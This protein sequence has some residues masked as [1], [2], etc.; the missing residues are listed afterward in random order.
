[1][2]GLTPA[3]TA[4]FKVDFNTVRA[5]CN[6][7]HGS[8]CLRGDTRSRKQIL[9]NRDSESLDPFLLCRI[10]TGNYQTVRGMLFRAYDNA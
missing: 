7:V 10:D 1:M 2:T 3:Y 6:F 4:S 9:I 8:L 5:L